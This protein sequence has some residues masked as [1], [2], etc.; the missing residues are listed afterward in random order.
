MSGCYEVALDA[1][2][3]LQ[4]VAG[5]YVPVDRALR[6][7]ARWERLVEWAIDILITRFPRMYIAHALKH[8]C[9]DTPLRIR[10]QRLVE[11]AMDVLITRFPRMYIDHA[12][13]EWYIDT[14]LRIYQ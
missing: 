9:T 6:T 1:T 3:V 2:F 7:V 5:Q 8:W 4:Y 11:G 12:L 13:M 10:W 14:R